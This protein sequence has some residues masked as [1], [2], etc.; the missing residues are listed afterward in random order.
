MKTETI[1]QEHVMKNP[2]SFPLLLVVAVMFVFG[3]C[4]ASNTGKATREYWPTRGWR[5]S[6]PER[7]GL[8]SEKLGEIKGYLQAELPHISSILVVRN[9]Y[10]VFEEYYHGDSNTL[11]GIFSGTK[12]II[13]ALVGMLVTDGLVRSVDDKITEYLPESMIQNVSP[14]A[15]DMTVR[16]LLTMTSGIPLSWAVDIFLNELSSTILSE[17]VESKPGEFFRYKSPD[18][19]FLSV[20]ITETTGLKASQYARE[21]LFS[22]L[23]IKDYFWLDYEDYSVGTY[24]LKLTSRDLVKIGYLYLR[25]GLWEGT[26]LI[27]QSY[28]EDS[29]KWQVE[30]PPEGNIWSVDGLHYGYLWWLWPM[31]GY[32][33]YSPVGGRGGQ[34]MGCVFPELNMIAVITADGNPEENINPLSILEDYILEAIAS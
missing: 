32:T 20:V 8:D 30:V 21:K 3:G 1:C 18:P 29:V 4:T 16:H 28:I 27:A 5:T 19:D 17:P 25:K 13:S 26:Q 9:G 24:G 22:P 33:V 34:Y 23:G 2:L 12:S 11:R 10:L 31:K 6:K 15:S 7:Q 14:G